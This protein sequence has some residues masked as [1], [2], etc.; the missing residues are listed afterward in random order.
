M[1]IL[2]LHNCSKKNTTSTYTSVGSVTLSW[3]IVP[4]FATSGAN[5]AAPA[6]TRN[7]LR[8]ICAFNAVPVVD[9]KTGGANAA[10]AERVARTMAKESFMVTFRGNVCSRRKR[11][12]REQHSKHA[13]H[14]ISPKYSKNNR[15]LRKKFH[16]F[17]FKTL[18]TELHAIHNATCATIAK[19]PHA[20]TYSWSKQICET[21]KRSWIKV[22]A[23]A[24]CSQQ[25]VDV[26]ALVIFDW[27]LQW[28]HII[29]T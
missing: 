23:I 17:G 2:I 13:S 15:I 14:I 9:G 8:P 26:K 27:H 21:T 3:P 19:V 4:A 1:R 6:A 16:R 7:S 24:I 20:T 12:I 22:L 18:S 25:E 5:I 29:T 11:S 28:C 10:V